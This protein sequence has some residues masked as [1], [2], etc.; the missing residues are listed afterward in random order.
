MRLFTTAAAVSILAANFAGAHMMLVSP[1]R[2]SQPVAT[3]GPLNPDG[4]NWPCQQV[5]GGSY[6]PG[7]QMNIYPLGS[8]QIIAL[9]GTAVHGGGSMQASI[10]YDTDP[11]KNSVWKVIKSWEGGAVAI[12]QAGNMGDDATA[13]DPYT[14]TFEIPDI[15]VGNGTVQWT[16]LNKIG[17]RELYA[18]CAPI[19][20]TGNGGSKANYDALPD[21]FLA[22]IGNDCGTVPAMD[23]LYPNPGSVV[24]RLNG[25]TTAF[26]APTG[27]G[28]QKPTGGSD[29][30]PTGAEATAQGLGASSPAQKGSSAANTNIPGGVFM[31]VSVGQSTSAMAQAAPSITSHAQAPP[32][33][34]TVAQAPPAVVTT[35]AVVPAANSGSG[36]SSAMSGS[37]V[38]EGEFNCIG[39]T[40]YQQCASGSWSVA[41]P[42]AAGTKCTGGLGSVLNIVPARRRVRFNV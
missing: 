14:Y 7:A 42:L 2:F 30:Q 41:M 28:C 12:G 27:A 18:Q 10:T 26:A 40:S 4:S 6:T 29:A 38:S 31:T 1:V 36:S 9:E 32:A 34:T 20:I 5:A 3:Q 16:W 25:D 37:C 13:P 15:P 21:V 22:N 35:A 19:V 17:N 8:K 39:G 33:A 11:D 23:A 24:E